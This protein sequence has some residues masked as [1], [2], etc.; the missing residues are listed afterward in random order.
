MAETLSRTWKLDYHYPTPPPGAPSTS[1]PLLPLASLPSCHIVEVS[2]HRLF[3]TCSLA[4]PVLRSAA[5]LSFPDLCN[6]TPYIVPCAVERGRLISTRLLSFAG[7]LDLRTN[8][9]STRQY[10][11]FRTCLDLKDARQRAH[12]HDITTNPIPKDICSSIAR[13]SLSIHVGSMHV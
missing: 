10:L 8:N 4:L 1:S 5:T 7:S 11:R 3:L 9:R 12:R 2:F 6:H 13:Q